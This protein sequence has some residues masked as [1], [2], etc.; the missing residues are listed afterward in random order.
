MSAAKPALKGEIIRQGS[1][2]KVKVIDI[3]KDLLSRDSEM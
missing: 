2:D 1:L 3:K